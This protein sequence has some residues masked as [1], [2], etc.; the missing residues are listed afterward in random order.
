M[1]SAPRV[2]LPRIGE[3]AAAY[4]AR[5]Q[6]GNPVCR[7]SGRCQLPSARLRQIDMGLPVQ[8]V[9]LRKPMRELLCHIGS[10]F[11]TASADRGAKGCE[12]PGGTT[13]RQRLHFLYSLKHH[14]GGASAPAGVDCRHEPLIGVG[15]QDRET[16]RRLDSN[17]DPRLG[18]NQSV[19]LQP[20]APFVA[21]DDERRMDLLELPPGSC[22]TSQRRTEG[23][24]KPLL[25]IQQWRP[26]K[27]VRTSVKSGC[28]GTHAAGFRVWAT[29]ICRWKSASMDSSSR[30]SVGRS[31]RLIWSILSCSFSRP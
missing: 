19:R 30:T 21:G 20:F 7:Y 18:G 24:L 8:V 27:A 17:A 16:V 2:E 31:T 15:Q 9:A 26:P 29:M 12:K 6:A 28:R 25:G 10:H 5:R 23:M 22:R 14:S 4:R 1:V 3:P 13:F 11:E